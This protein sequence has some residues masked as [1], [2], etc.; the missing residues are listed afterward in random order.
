VLVLVLVLVIV[1]V[2][3]TPKREEPGSLRSESD[4]EHR[5]AALR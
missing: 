1:I 2:I 3:D 4:D 5:G